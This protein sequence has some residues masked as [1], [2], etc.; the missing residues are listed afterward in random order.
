M[1]YLV[2]MLCLI[3]S[4]CATNK[5]VIL[6]KIAEQCNAHPEKFACLDIGGVNRD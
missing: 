5:D 3:M 2:M 6:E 4:G 1:K